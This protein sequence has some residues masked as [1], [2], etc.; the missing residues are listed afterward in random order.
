MCGSR[1]SIWLSKGYVGTLSGSV[2]LSSPLQSAI[3]QKGY[4]I[5]SLVSILHVAHALEAL[6]VLN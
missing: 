2:A 3:F 1:L 5:A 4:I 6:F